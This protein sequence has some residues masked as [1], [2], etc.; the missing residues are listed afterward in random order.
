[1][2]V[3][4]PDPRV[5]LRRAEP[6]DVAYLAMLVSDPSV[7]PFLAAITARTSEEL[8]REVERCAADPRQAGRLV[9][10]ASL[11]ATPERVGSIAYDVEN[12][13]SR[14]AYLHSLMVEP[15]A[16][17][18]GIG[19][20]AAVAAA[21]LLIHDEDY[22]RVQL[23]IYGF[24][25]AAMRLAER[26]GFTREGTRRRAYRRRGRWVDGVLFGLVAED[27]TEGD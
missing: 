19:T 25:E 9:V 23:E 6:S 16:R 26:A 10:E 4:T 22:H 11:G 12:R 20:A 8:T 24:N 13:R 7:E 21:R 17:G 1:M 3:R 14:I 5:L 27:L 18:L 15:R 2:N